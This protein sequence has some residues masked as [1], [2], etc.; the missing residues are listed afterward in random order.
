MRPRPSAF[1]VTEV[2]QKAAKQKATEQKAG[3]VAGARARGGEASGSGAIEIGPGREEGGFG[4]ATGGGEGMFSLLFLS[5]SIFI[6]DWL[7]GLICLDLIYTIRKNNDINH[8]I[9]ASL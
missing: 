4:E 3:S 6:S 5:A 2:Q 1:A 9:L 7:D 8:A